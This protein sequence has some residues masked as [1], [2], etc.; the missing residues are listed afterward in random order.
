MKVFLDTNI[1]IDYLAHRPQFYHNAALT[2]SICGD[3]GYQMLVS[4]LAIL[5]CANKPMSS[6]PATRTTL[7]TKYRTPSMQIVALA[8]EKGSIIESFKSAYTGNTQF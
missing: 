6:S 5:P 7:G 2:V 3:K 1:L 4:A 8:A